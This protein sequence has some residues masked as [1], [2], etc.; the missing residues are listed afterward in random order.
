MIHQS[1]LQTRLIAGVTP[2]YLLVE[3]LA[4][5][6][7]FMLFGASKFTLTVVLLLAL[8][9]HRL[10]AHWSRRDADTVR[11]FFDAVRYP[12]YLPAFADPFGAGAATPLPSIAR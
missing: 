12:A 3:L 6:G 7:V 5:G 4:L 10:G 1:L 2:D 8:G 11:L 9:T